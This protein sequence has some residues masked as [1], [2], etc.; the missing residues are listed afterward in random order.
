MNIPR[1]FEGSYGV[2][3]TLAVPALCPF[4]VVSTAYALFLRQAAANLG[5]ERTALEVVSGLANAGY[6]FGALLGGDLMQ[7]FRQRRLFLLCEGLFIAGCVLS[8]VA[9]GIVAYGSGRVLQGFAT[10]LLLVVAL[11]ISKGGSKKTGR[12][13]A[14]RPWRKACATSEENPPGH[15]CLCHSVMPQPDTCTN[16][17]ADAR[18]R[19]RPLAG[20]RTGGELLLLEPA[21]G[22]RGQAR[23]SAPPD[24]CR[25]SGIGKLSGIGHGCLCHSVPCYVELAAGIIPGRR[26]YDTEARMIRKLGFLLLFLAPGI[27]DSMAQTAAA[28]GGARIDLSKGWA[29]QSSAKVAAKGAEISTSKFQPQG[30]Y[31]AAIPSTVIAALVNN[32]VYPDPYF[33]MNLRSIPGTAYNIGANFANVAKPADS[34]FAVPWWYRT[35]FKLPSS[36]RG[37]RLWL[38]FDS[39][40]CR[41]NIWLNGRQLADSGQVA[42]M[43]RTFE[44]DITDAAL[45]GEDNTLAVEVMPPTPTDLSITFVDWNPMPADKDM[46]IVRAVYIRTSGPVAVRNAQVVSRLDNPPD[47]AHL[48]LY[49]D[50][51]NAA[52]S[53]LSGTLK[54]TIESVSVSKK[55]TLAAG[56]S[57]RVALTPAEFPQLNL[58]HPRLWWP[59]GLGPQNLY[60]LRMEF[61][62]AGAVSDRQDVE[63]GI[64]DIRGEN[65]SENHRVFRI[66]GKRILIRGGGWTQDMLLRVNDGREA[67]EIRYARDMHLNAI[68]LEG[69]MMNEHFF[70][71]ADRYGMMVMPGWCCCSFW[72]RWREWKPEDYK[73]AGESLRDQVRLLRNHPSVFVF[74]YGSDNSPNP[75]AE[76]VYLK[77]L[78]EEHWPNPYI[79][80]ATNATTPG[81]GIT[82]VKMT[83]PYDYVAPNYWL[84]DTRRGGAFGFNTETS[85][86]PAIPVL[87]SLREMLPKEH[88]WPIDS[89]WEFHAGG[90]AYRNVNVFTTALENRYGKA[91]DL[92]DY[93]RKS[94][95]MTYEGE[96]AMFEA[97]GRNKYNST[98]VIQWMAN[99]AWP[100]IIWHLYDWYLRPGGGYFGTKKANELL[101]VQYSYD[102]Q[103]IVVVN[104]NYKAFPGCKVTARIYNIDLTGKFSRTAAV[105]IPED[106]STRVFTLPKVDG[107]SRTYFVRL[108]LDDPAGKTVSTNFYWLS[109]QPDVS[110][111]ER[112]NG[113]FTPIKTYTDLTAL[114]SLPPVKVTVQSRAEQ[115]GVDQLEHVTVRN[116]STH[117]AFMVHLTVLKGED[118]GDVAPVY[119]EDNYFE[120]MPGE[121]REISA[122]YPRKLLGG[123][124]PYIKVD[125]WNVTQ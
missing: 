35:V 125:G 122:T 109:T 75:E 94:Q 93:L 104:S 38:N 2:S 7:R 81:A 41:A 77:V 121:G 117:L 10:G 43:Y 96:R 65:D 55:V 78:E 36:V 64:R 58:A 99:N 85:P 37:K 29:I 46:G 112:G 111:W 102:D 116:P 50:L 51:R 63:F 48:T 16:C 20:L 1:P 4:I 26:Q 80:S 91:K 97:F 124:R 87:E 84:E 9:G 61:E 74:L 19:G 110:D 54:G 52:G 44:F 115:R 11:P 24:F 67:Y 39:I 5:T 119:W 95:A 34:P 32:K 79:S 103:S 88:L 42:G 25:I 30:W 13:S 21:G 69:K 83:G 89:F 114:E 105:D 66:N 118:G 40:N 28:G 90:G 120:L 57:T 27:G 31:P 123:A 107:L 86:G 60:R 100:S 45:P 47:A 101:H 98:G 17:G 23:G 18:V 92:P 73:I 14:R 15:G 113:R 72:E 49:A 82:G 68:R 62:A 59:Y 8:G 76:K 53:A 6:A 71:T 22:S 70:S 106:S 56:E 3:L 12:L 33:G 108:S